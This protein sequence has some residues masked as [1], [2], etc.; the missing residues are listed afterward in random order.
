MN[1]PA[2]V[3]IGSPCLLT[4][5]FLALRL[6]GHINWSWWWVLSPVWIPLAFTL[7]MMFGVFLGVG[8]WDD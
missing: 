1:K 3:I 6:V 5:I 2:I 7:W 8:Q 4:C